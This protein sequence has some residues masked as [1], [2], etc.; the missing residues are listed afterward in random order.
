MRCR[1]DIPAP[2]RTAATDYVVMSL[3][4][5]MRGAV[6]AVVLIAAHAGVAS[7]A[8]PTVVPSAAEA[9]S[10]ATSNGGWSSAVDYGNLAC[11]PGV[12]CPTANPTYR[13][14]GGI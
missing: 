1:S 14:T 4:S 11:I 9:R 10:F 5:L 2:K 3:R 12:T 7:A 6:L 8:T 13:S